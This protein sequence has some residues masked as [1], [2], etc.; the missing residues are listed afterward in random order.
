ME[1]FPNHLAVVEAAADAV[2]AFAALDWAGLEGAFQLLLL[3]LCLEVC[4]LL[5]SETPPHRVSLSTSP[6]AGWVLWRAG[7]FISLLPRVVVTVSGWLPEA[8]KRKVTAWAW[9][10]QMGERSRALRIPEI[11]CRR[12][13]KSS[14]GFFPWTFRLV[15][16]F[17]HFSPEFTYLWIHLLLL[18]HTPYKFNPHH[19]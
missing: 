13:L 17:R 2:W 7:S 19:C 6:P 14:H 18:N 1:L 3:N 4:S 15:M 16:P 5:A 11:S 9:A 12:G 10:L 8:P